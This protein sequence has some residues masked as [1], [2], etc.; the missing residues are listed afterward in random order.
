MKWTRSRVASAV[1]LGTASALV[2]AACG[3]DTDP[4]DAPTE[5][6]T[7]T[8]REPVTLTL[9]YFENF[10]FE[11][12]KDQY[13]AENPHVTFEEVITEWGAHHDNLRQLIFAGSGAPNVVAVDGDFMVDFITQAENF[14]NLLDLGGSQYEER[15]LPWKWSQAATADL[16][17]VIGFGS[18][19]GGLA[20]CYRQDL[21]E[22]AGLEHDRDA[23][24]DI[25]GDSWSDF[26][27][28][29]EQYVAATG[30]GFIDNANNI[31]NPA[32]TQLGIGY[33]DR[34]NQLDLDSA[35]PAFDVA[36]DA[37]DRGLSANIGAWSGEWNAGFANGDFAVLACPGWMRGVITGALTGEGVEFDGQW[38]VATIPG[39]GGNWG[40]SFYMLP[41]QNFSD[42]EI[43]EAYR[44]IEWIIQPEQQLAIFEALGNIPSQ[45]TLLEQLAEEDVVSFGDFFNGAP[46]S[47]FIE[48]ALDIPGAIYFAPKHGAVRGALENVLGD[49]QSGVIPIADAWEAAV[50]AAE[51]A[52]AQ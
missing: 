34:N 7:D 21:F 35:R 16:N 44:F 6:P 39:P 45:I 4:T 19:V 36:V 42:Y 23:L 37:I 24:G 22:A 3:G 18:D 1:A 15:F 25:W 28:F 51:A 30:N 31:L 5:E 27:D 33:Y 46:E 32:L 17:T 13:L 52:D 49:I 8:P 43:Q 47:I 12:V 50:A 2:L 20:M 38:D 29:G 48:S 40:G 11:I 9:G 41:R 10:G 14:V 26:L